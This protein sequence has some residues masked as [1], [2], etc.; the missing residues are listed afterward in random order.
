MIIPF[1]KGG[2]LEMGESWAQCA[3]REVSD[4]DC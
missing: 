3:I 1:V 4:R 2:H